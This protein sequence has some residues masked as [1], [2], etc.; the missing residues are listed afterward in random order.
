MKELEIRD[1]RD[2]INAVWDGRLC[3]FGKDL[4]NELTKQDVEFLRKYYFYKVYKGI[5][6]FP[7]CLRITVVYEHNDSFKPINRDY[8]SYY[9]AEFD[10]IKEVVT[11]EVTTAYGTTA[12]LKAIP[13]EKRMTELFKKAELLYSNEQTIENLYLDNNT[14]SV[15]CIFTDKVKKFNDDGVSGTDFEEVM[16]K[17]R[18]ILHDIMLDLRDI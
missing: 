7:P 5:D 8:I 11:Y 12:S 16:N 9:R 3:R 4:K 13:D 1:S 15:E 10:R 6:N 14:T 2:L 17:A 18:S